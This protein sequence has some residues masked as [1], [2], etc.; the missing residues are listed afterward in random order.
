[1]RRKSVKIE[2][3]LALWT[4]FSHHI[5]DI[6]DP[7]HPYSLKELKVI[8]EDVIEGHVHSHSR[9]L[10]HGN[11]YWPLFMSETYAQPALPLQ[12]MTNIPLPFF[13]SEHIFQY[14]LGCLLENQ[15]FEICLAQLLVMLLCFSALDKLITILLLDHS[16]SFV[17]F[18]EIIWN[19]G[20]NFPSLNQ[21]SNSWSCEVRPLLCKY[22]CFLSLMLSCDV[23]LE[24][25]SFEMAW[26][27]PE[28]SLSLSLLEVM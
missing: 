8:T 7:E 22:W 5:R 25:Q 13:C 16:V 17:S 20:C 23:E 2:L 1:M 26:G 11:G 27:S 24:R 15:G 3:N 12:G 28:K 9:T 19:S 21:I 4:T 18:L 6:K 14:L 10:Q